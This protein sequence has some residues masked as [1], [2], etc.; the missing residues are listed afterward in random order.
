MDEHLKQGGA[1]LGRRRS[2]G[3]ARSGRGRRQH[4]RVQCRLRADCLVLPTI[5]VRVRLIGHL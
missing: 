4:A 3:G 2:G 1:A 5:R